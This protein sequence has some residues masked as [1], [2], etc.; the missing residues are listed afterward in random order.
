M[1]P[2]DVIGWHCVISARSVSNASS[3]GDACSVINEP[4]VLVVPGV[5]LGARSV[6]GCQECLWMSAVVSLGAQSVGCD[7]CGFNSCQKSGSKR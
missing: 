4:E 2:G 6:T 1:V 5:S 7:A 3:V